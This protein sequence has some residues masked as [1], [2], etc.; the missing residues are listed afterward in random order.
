MKRYISHLCLFIALLVFTSVSAQNVEFVKSNFPGKE[1][2]FKEAKSQYK[3]GNKYFDMGRGMYRTAL[4]L[5]LKANSFNPSCA[6]LNYKIGK[7]YISTIQKTNSIQYLEKAYALDP[8]V[9]PD[10][11]YLL[12]QAYHLNLE[13][14]KAI[15]FLQ[16]YKATLSPDMLSQNGPDIE[17]YIK[18]CNV[19]KDLVKK[20]VRVFIDNLGSNINTMYPEYSP[21]ITADESQ[22]FFTSRRDITTGGKLDENDLQ[23]YED[24]FFSDKTASGW[25]KATNPKKPLNSDKHDATVGLSPDGQVLLIYKGTNGGDI[26]E[27]KLKGDQ[28]SA[29]SKLKINTKYHESS[30][31][32]S[33]D[34][35]TMYFVSDR[36][37]GY[38]GGDIYITKKDEKGRWTAPVNAG[39]VINTPED[40]EGVFMQ[41]DGK[42]LYFSSKGH[43]GMG[44]FDIF[45]ATFE[46]NQWTE[47]VNMGYPINTPDDDVFFSI[48]ASGVHGYYSSVKPEGYGAQDIYEITFL[49]AEKPVIN[50]TEDNLLA[51]QTQPVSET[52]IEPV[53]A[54]LDNQVTLLK[55]II[56]D[57]IN[58]A[59]VGAV[60]EITDLD[61]N[62]VISSFES[63][64]KTGK[65]LVSLPSG[66][67]YGITVKAEGY[68][69]HSENLNIPPTTTY[70]EINKD[71]KLKKVE[72][73]STIVLNNIF[74]DFN[75]ATLRPESASELDRLVKLLTD[76][77]TLKIEIAGH[78][79]NIGASAYNKKLS[80][81]RAKSVVDYLVGK[82]IAAT[83]LTF[84]GYGFDKPIATNDTEE[85]RQMNRRTEF[86]IISK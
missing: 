63:N 40:E 38:G 50:N 85:G 79:D 8:A 71:I 73:G 28:W 17:K 19:G 7:C 69:F 36:P 82:G 2:E 27:C 43:N 23:Y 35:R 21:L 62:E 74:F 41:S 13:F 77:P 37:D 15:Q 81:Q 70:R 84:V 24:I 26:Y 33:F 14:D 52:V 78:T 55:G 3:Q 58:L 32:I 44:G 6:D 68:L 25:T 1:K 64:S 12:G 80:E 86:K 56:S 60:I 31:S 45:K 20:P 59:P 76:L 22:I 34:G 16:E 42:T 53:V 39:P 10:I 9:A 67:N 51:S 72:V 48:A 54:I 18:A 61:K 75:K 49:G 5:F 46:N 11:K 57:E 29:P 66:K 4:E 65:Y 47:P 30:A 83:R